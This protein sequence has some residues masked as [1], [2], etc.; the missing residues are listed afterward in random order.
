MRA[1]QIL[2][3]EDDLIT[4]LSSCDFLRDRG[5]RVLEVADARSAAEIVDQRG[6]LSGLVCDIDLGPGDDGFQVA[7]RTRLAYP[8]LPVVFVSAAAASRHLAEGVDGSIFIPK[9]YHPRQ[10]ADALFSLAPHQAP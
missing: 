6:Y 5:F 4:S 7:R 8:G 2:F 3:V 9:P 10:I 1:Q